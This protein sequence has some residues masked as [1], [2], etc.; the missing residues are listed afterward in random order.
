MV[1]N[2]PGQ[3][4]WGFLLGLAL[5]GLGFLASVAAE[6]FNS[7]LENAGASFRAT[8]VVL[9]DMKKAFANGLSV[10]VQARPIVDQTATNANVLATWK[11]PGQPQR[12]AKLMMTKVGNTWYWSG[13]LYL[14]P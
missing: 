7:A 9:A 13:V 14:R 8:S 6:C 3:W 2:E 12:N 4:R 1:L 10:V 5:D 11:D